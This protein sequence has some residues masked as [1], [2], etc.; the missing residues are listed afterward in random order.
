[1]SGWRA[2]RCSTR[3]MKSGRQESNLPRTAY[4]TVASP[5]G[6]RPAGLL[7]APCT[8]VDPVSP[9]RQAGRHPAASQ[10]GH[11]L[12]KNGRIRTHSAGFG[13]RLLSQEHVLV[14]AV[15]AGLEPAPF[16]LTA[17]RT[18]V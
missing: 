16:P 15:P 5:P 14:K 18:T 2:L 8:G 13:D 12:S 10:G 11:L 1:M 3:L 7:R 9:A 17:G 6:P 4:Q